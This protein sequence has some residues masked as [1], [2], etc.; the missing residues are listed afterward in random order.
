MITKEDAA[1]K[2]LSDWIA[3]IKKLP[4]WVKIYKLNHHSPSQINTEGPAIN[5]L[6]SCWLFPQKEQ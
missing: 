3:G 5:F 6:T 4:E 1:E 2:A